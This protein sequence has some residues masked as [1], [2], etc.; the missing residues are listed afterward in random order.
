LNAKETTSDTISGHKSQPIKYDDF[1]ST[2]VQFGYKYGVTIQVFGAG[3]NVPPMEL[4]KS[5]SDDDDTATNDDNSYTGRVRQNQCQHYSLVPAS[6]R[7]R[8]FGLDD[9]TPTT[10]DDD[11]KNVWQA[12]YGETNIEYTTCDWCSKSCNVCEGTRWSFGYCDYIPDRWVYTKTVFAL[13]LSCKSALGFALFYVTYFCDILI[14]LISSVIACCP[15]K[16][17]SNDTVKYSSMSSKPT[18]KLFKTCGP[19]GV[20]FAVYQFIFKWM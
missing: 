6:N 13:L 12:D 1:V 9:D 2:N 10:S 19:E 16:A 8:L 4:F 3:G 14:N 5:Q 15:F 20:F 18:D 11:V 7:R 17:C